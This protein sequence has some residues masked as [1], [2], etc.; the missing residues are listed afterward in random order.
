MPTPRPII[1]ASVGA[2]VGTSAT[3]LIS[4]M[5]DRPQTRPMIAVM[6]GR[7]IATTV[8]NV[9]SRTITAMRQA[10]DL[11]DV[12]LGLGDLLAEV[13]AEADLEPGVAGRIR[14][15]DDALG[16]VERS[17]R[18]GSACRLSAM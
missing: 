13:A 15:R 1:V 10:D 11:A 6:I 7:P 5:I 2:T 17:A 14:E 18:S 4:V 9:N 16:V 3:W 12:R 8:P